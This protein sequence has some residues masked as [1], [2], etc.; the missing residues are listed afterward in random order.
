[1]NYSEHG[2]VIDGIFYCIEESE[3]EVYQPPQP[4]YNPRDPPLAIGARKI[5]A[6]RRRKYAIF[7]FFLV[8]SSKKSPL[9]RWK[10][11]NQTIKSEPENEKLK[12]LIL[13]YED[14]SEDEEKKQAD[15]QRIKRVAQARKVSFCNVT[16]LIN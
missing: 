3:I 7:A 13:N 6:A 9:F 15:E 4:S 16:V 1:M 14:L 2:T 5:L 10:H 12:S 11:L 8:V